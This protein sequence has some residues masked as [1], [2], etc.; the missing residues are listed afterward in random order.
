MYNHIAYWQPIV[1][2]ILFFAFDVLLSLAMNY[3][4]SFSPTRSPPFPIPSTRMCTARLPLVLLFTFTVYLYSHRR[5][6]L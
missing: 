2:E 1:S 4:I 6:A 5:L 3:A